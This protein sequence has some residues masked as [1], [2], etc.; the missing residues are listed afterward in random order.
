MVSPDFQIDFF[1]ELGD[2]RSLPRSD[3]KQPEEKEEWDRDSEDD[4]ES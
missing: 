4:E 3:Y 1:V 2:I